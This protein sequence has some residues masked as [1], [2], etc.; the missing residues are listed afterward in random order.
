MRKDACESGS[1]VV[2]C[3]STYEQSACEAQSG[4]NDDG[5]TVGTGIEVS[6]SWEID[7]EAG[8]TEDRGCPNQRSYWRAAPNNLTKIT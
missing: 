7:V 8:N 4:L 3:K 1:R 2:R 5:L 6:D